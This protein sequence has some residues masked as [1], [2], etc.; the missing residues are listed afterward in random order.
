MSMSMMHKP[1]MINKMLVADFGGSMFRVLQPILDE[2]KNMEVI[3]HTLS[4]STLTPGDAF[5]ESL[6]L[7]LEDL[8]E[9]VQGREVLVLGLTGEQLLRPPPFEKIDFKIEFRGKSL[10]IHVQAVL[11]RAEI[12]GELSSCFLVNYLLEGPEIAGMFA[13]GSSSIRAALQGIDGS[14][15]Y[16]EAI[17]GG[18]FLSEGL[19]TPLLN[20]FEARLRS[21]MKEMKEAPVFYFIGGFSY[22]IASFDGKRP[23]SSI[24]E[25]SFKPAE[26]FDMF[27]NGLNKHYEAV[28]SSV[29][30]ITINGK[31]FP[32]IDFKTVPACLLGMA[33]AQ[34]IHRDRPDASIIIAREVGTVP[35]GWYGR[36]FNEVD[37]EVTEARRISFVNYVPE[38]EEMEM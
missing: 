14:Y 9:D 22:G 29:P 26:A 16:Q 27:K 4:S 7:T 33:L 8:P 30:G 6:K 21:D 36:L 23:F 19:I 24:K 5:P 2:G 37:L 13:F 20:F 18:N 32:T 28:A 15:C 31:L 35:L 25:V 38:E 10:R 1:E 11:S 12:E 17:P 34:I 3:K